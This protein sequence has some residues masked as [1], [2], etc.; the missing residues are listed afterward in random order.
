MNEIRVG[1][2]GAGRGAD[3]SYDQYAAGAKVVALCDF[4]EKRRQDAADRLIKDK[5]FL[6]SVMKAGADE[7]S[8]YARKIMSKVRRKIGFVN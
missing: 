7:A 5:A 6:E 3:I 8:Y 4:H 1:I 2:F